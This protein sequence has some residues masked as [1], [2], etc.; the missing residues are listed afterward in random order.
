MESIYEVWED[1]NEKMLSESITVSTREGIEKSKS[2]GDLSLRAKLLYTITASTWEDA[3]V[4][5]YERQGWGRYKP[6]D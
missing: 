3:M 6:M 4:I 1:Y 2:Q 5:H